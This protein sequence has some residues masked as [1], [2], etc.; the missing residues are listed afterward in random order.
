MKPKSG[1]ELSTKTNSGFTMGLVSA[2]ILGLASTFQSVSASKDSVDA[3]EAEA[4]R[5]GCADKT[6][7][8]ARMTDCT[9]T[10][11]PR[12]ETRYEVESFSGLGIDKEPDVELDLYLPLS[13]F[14]AS[15]ITIGSGQPAF[16]GN[17]NEDTTDIDRAVLVFS[18]Q[19]KI[20]P[21]GEGSNLQLGLLGD[22]RVL[23]GAM[24]NW[25]KGGHSPLLADETFNNERIRNFR[26]ARMNLAIPI[27]PRWSSRIEFTA[28]NTNSDADVLGLDDVF[29]FIT[30]NDV[31]VAPAIRAELHNQLNDAIEGA[32]PE[33]LEQYHE[34]E[35]ILRTEIDD[36]SDQQIVH[37]YEEIVALTR[38]YYPEYSQPITGEEFVGAVAA[39]A[40]R[41]NLDIMTVNNLLSMM[42]QGQADTSKS[43]YM[44]KVDFTR[45]TER[46]SLT[47]GI[48]GG[49]IEHGKTTFESAKIMPFSIIS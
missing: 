9:I 30:E 39:L 17:G 28:G 15:E 8:F 4:L 33:F 31:N 25:Y 3:A 24:S 35:E 22:E 38:L 44:L 1:I 19:R 26:G 40:G 45:Q 11:A 27:S 13:S 12:I 29:S 49:R 32:D 21:F 37:A 46:S 43:S 2:S 34:L 20:G 36:L 16:S 47:F 5:G 18:T 48:E 42:R 10:S 41:D 14:L 23:E 6:L 7:P